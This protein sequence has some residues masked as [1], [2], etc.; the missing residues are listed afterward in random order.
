M[1]IITLQKRKLVIVIL[2][3]C[4]LWLAYVYLQSVAPAVS[5]PTMDDQMGTV[6]GTQG[7]TEKLNQGSHDKQAALQEETL[8]S[9]KNEAKDKTQGDGSDNKAAEDKNDASLPTAG[10]KVLPET[11]QTAAYFVNYRMEREKV[12]SRQLE[13]LNE[14]VDNTK[15]TETMR[16]QA[17]EKLMTITQEM[18]DELKL[19]N[20]LLA[21]N[22]QDAAVFI[23]PESVL[24]VVPD[25]GIGN[26]DRVKIADLVSNTTG[27]AYED[28]F[29][30]T[31]N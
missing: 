16:S 25:N 22:Y 31:K 2:V 12:R 4:L 10:F 5:P 18:E 29:I 17:Q 26:L 15:S 3:V 27:H 14:I 13:I 24:V 1:R 30:T 28:I 6:D 23:Q 21:K 19:E 8:N 11:S 7:G 9:T 20:L